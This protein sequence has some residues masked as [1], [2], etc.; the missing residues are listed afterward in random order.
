M[1]TDEPLPLEK[2]RII[3]NEDVVE[4]HV[5]MFLDCAGIFHR[6]DTG[7]KWMLPFPTGIGHNL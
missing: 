6:N 1:Q 3:L 5:R 7:F 2:Y 4:S